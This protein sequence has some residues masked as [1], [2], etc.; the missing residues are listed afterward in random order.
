[1]VKLLA[2]RFNSKGS[3]DEDSTLSV[4]DMKD[5]SELLW[6][7]YTQAPLT[8]DVPVHSVH[9]DLSWRVWV[10]VVPEYGTATGEVLRR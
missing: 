8:S 5:K 1:M 10:G 7:A 2:T 6:Y 3:I 9:D 4:N